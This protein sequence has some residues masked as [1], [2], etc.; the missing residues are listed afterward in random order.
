M[1]GWYTGNSL[2][3][4]RGVIST[5]IKHGI[6]GS[7]F[8]KFWQ[9]VSRWTRYAIKEAEWLQWRL[10]A[11]MWTFEQV[12]YRWRAKC[13][14]RPLFIVNIQFSL[15]YICKRKPFSLGPA[16]IWKLTC[17]SCCWCRPFNPLFN[18]FDDSVSVR[19]MS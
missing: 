11:G 2:N 1:I 17:S 18:W 3:C 15:H 4:N 5:I 10:P 19:P 6:M 9:G 13:L 12:Y 8:K 7:I 16:S 14:T